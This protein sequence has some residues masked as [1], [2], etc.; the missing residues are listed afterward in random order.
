MTTP[1]ACQLHQRR[2]AILCGRVGR[3]QIVRALAVERIDDEHV[4]GGRIA[5]GLLIHRT[6]AMGDLGTG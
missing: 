6:T 1:H 4:R 3:K 5:F 2:D